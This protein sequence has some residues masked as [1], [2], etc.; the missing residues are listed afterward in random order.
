MLCLDVTRLVSR[1]GRG[2]YTGIDRVEYAWLVGLLDRNLPLTGLA[3]TAA[4]FC[5]FD[6]TGLSALKDRLD[7]RI[8]WG[9]P[10]LVSRLSRSLNPARRAAEADLRR[11]AISSATRMGLSR[12]LTKSL[13]PG[14]LYLNLG[15]SNLDAPVLRAVSRYARVVV[16][17]HDMIPLDLP[18]TQRPG[19]AERFR[20]R[21]LAVRD[22][23]D[24]IVC[25][26]HAA[27]S[28]VR[29]YIPE[30]APIVAPLGVTLT[31]PG[32]MAPRITAP[33][34]SCLGTIDMRKNQ[35]LLLDVWEELGL[36]A[37]PLY[38]LGNRGWCDAAL[39]AR[40]D[41]CPPNI[42]EIPNLDDGAVAALIAQSTCLLHPSLAEGYG[43]PPLEA[44]LRG[45]PVI[46]SDLPVFRETLADIPIYAGPDDRY[47]WIEKIKQV[48]DK[49]SSAP[50][51][52]DPASVQLDR[53]TWDRHLN[54]VL[55]QL[56]N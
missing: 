39:T 44:S 28:D 15:H 6:R 53:P 31:A 22:H 36:E 4:G 8:V 55:S 10:D 18:E 51:R 16:M 23:A 48:L 32:R 50:Q 35:S 46:C 52:R 45:V 5:F 19:M 25:P 37:P 42:H 7:G 56:W 12:L 27:A 21:V 24:F 43:L 13:K 47:Q 11:L 41:R 14:S 40:L 17:L 20:R 9:E 26:S 29:R 3:R 33:F 38:L 34:F 1:V 49:T 30:A 2:P 54:L